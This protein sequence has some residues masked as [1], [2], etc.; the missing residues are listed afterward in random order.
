MRRGWLWF[1]RELYWLKQQL[2]WRWHLDTPLGLMG[3]L[4]VVLGVG[5]LVTLGQALTGLFR[6]TIPWVA[7]SR[8]SAV[9]WQSV[10]FG[11]KAS[12]LFVMFTVSLIVFVVLKLNQR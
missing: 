4:A 10:A 9:Y 11:M 6:N 3:I 5:L 2:K 7:G 1:S 8:I 12:I